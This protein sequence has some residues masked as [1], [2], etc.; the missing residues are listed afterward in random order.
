MILLYESIP[1]TFPK[2]E[3]KKTKKNRRRI[4]IMKFTVV[5]GS[6]D[7]HMEEDAPGRVRNGKNGIP[8]IVLWTTA[9]MAQAKVKLKVKS[10]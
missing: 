7:N 1:I 2:E 4:R 5:F 8:S 9:K 10:H 3:Q 6:N